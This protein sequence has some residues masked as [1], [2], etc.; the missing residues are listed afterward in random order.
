M[1]FLNC[2]LTFCWFIEMLYWKASASS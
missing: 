1:K 2:S